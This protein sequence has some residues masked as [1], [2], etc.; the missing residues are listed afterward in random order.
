MKK[1]LTKA[2]LGLALAVGGL[3]AAPATS[4][5]GKMPISAGWKW[6]SLP[7]SSFCR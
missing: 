4:M 5:E 7:W 6:H 3:A 1:L 2:A